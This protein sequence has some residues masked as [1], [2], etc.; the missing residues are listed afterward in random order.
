MTKTILRRAKG[1][2]VM[3]PIPIARNKL[4]FEVNFGLTDGAISG[5][6]GS[7]QV[8][9]QPERQH[10][11]VPLQ[12]VSRKHSKLTVLA[13]QSPMLLL[14]IA[15]T[16]HLPGFNP[17]RGACS[18][19]RETRIRIVRKSRIQ[20]NCKCHTPFASDRFD[21]F[22]EKVKKGEAYKIRGQTVII[23]INQTVII[24]CLRELIK[25]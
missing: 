23:L 10:F 20:Y 21:S 7:M 14:E 24:R 2:N 17:D 25:R 12:F 4:P 6:S 9:A 13:E 18:V 3:C 15:F 8:K 11:F 22:Q 1:V 19:T 16:G 5:V